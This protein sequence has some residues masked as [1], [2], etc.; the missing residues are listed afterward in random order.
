[1]NTLLTSNSTSLAQT[2]QTLSVRDKNDGSL[3]H[4]KYVEKQLTSTPKVLAEEKVTISEQA[5]AMFRQEPSETQEATSA[6]D[7]TNDKLLEEIKEQIEEVQ[8]K[9]SRIKN[10][11]G[12]AA[13]QQ[14]R[15]LQLQLSTLNASMLDLLGK[16]LDAI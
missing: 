16:K 10:D 3:E 12:E 7:S 5:L 1:M 2:N 8:K 14:R 9:L 11:K 6:A 13:D 15:Q 4:M